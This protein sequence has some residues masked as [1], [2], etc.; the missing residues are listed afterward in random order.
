MSGGGRPAA[1][2]DLDRTLIAGS[3]AFVFAKAARAAGIVPLRQFASAAYQ[4]AKFAMTGATDA[5][6]ESVRD[7]MLAGVGG[8]RQSDIT[9]LNETVLPQLLGL[10]RPEARAVLDQH[11]RAGRAT[12]I[13]SASPVEIVEPLARALGMTGGIGTVAEVD[14]GLY[15][16]RLD[17]PFCYGP[18]K[19]EAIAALAERDG[20]DLANSWSY[21]DSASDVPMM[22]IVGHGV[23]VNPDAKMARIARD[24]G[25][26]TVVFSRPTATLVRRTSLASAAA[27]LGAACYWV[28]VR[29]GLR[30]A[31][32]VGRSAGRPR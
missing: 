6:S 24:R 32:S 26:P 13:V 3:S 9:E 16:G 1:F 30:L 20:I 31:R 11:H 5:T 10:I 7:Q 19:A 4:S 12:Y 23:A 29:R 8:L 2:F 28:G 22:E 21:S 14:D 18:G 27:T 17:G 15:T 25:W